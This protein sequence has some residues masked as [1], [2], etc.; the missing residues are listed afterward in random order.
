MI[1]L[2]ELASSTSS[3]REQRAPKRV[4]ADTGRPTFEEIANGLHNLRQSMKGRSDIGPDVVEVEVQF[5]FDFGLFRLILT[6][7]CL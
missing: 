2:S 1:N 3:S 5:I 6:I 7:D 4:K